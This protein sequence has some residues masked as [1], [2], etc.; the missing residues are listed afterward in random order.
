MFIFRSRIFNKGKRIIFQLM[1]KIKVM[2]KKLPYLKKDI[3]WAI[4]LGILFILAGK[5]SF[6]L[7]DVNNILFVIFALIAWK[8]KKQLNNEMN[9]VLSVGRVFS[10]LTVIAILYSF[11]LVFSYIFQPLGMAFVSTLLFTPLRLFMA[12]GLIVYT[13]QYY[14]FS[15]WKTELN[16]KYQKK[17]ILIEI[18]GLILIFLIGWSGILS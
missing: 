9:F 11:G 3:V 16:F 5:A 15:L 4:G 1:S 10:L 18:T 6:S 12:F 2:L 8:M 7:P 14:I 13:L 17:L